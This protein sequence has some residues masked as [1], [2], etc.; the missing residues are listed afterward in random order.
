MK[1]IESILQMEL[2]RSRPPV[3]I[4]IGAS[5]EINPKWKQIA[6]YSI[7]IAFD[8]DDREFNISEQDNKAYKKLI[9]FNRIVTAEPIDKADFYLTNSP[10]CSS[11]LEPDAVNLKPWIFSSFFSTEKKIQLPAITL[12]Q[13]LSQIKIDYID[14]FK[15]DTQGTDLRL[16]KTLPTKISD[17]I[18]AAEFEPGIIDAYRGED[19]IYSV[20]EYLHQ[21]KFW[22]SSME[23]KGV[24]RIDPNYKGKFSSFSLRKIIRRSP[25]WAEVT[26]LR[27][28]V[29]NGKREILLLYIFALLEKQYGFALEITDFA[30]N[31]FQDTVFKDCRK[32][33]LK[34]LNAEKWKM[35]LVI[36][37]RQFNKL[38]TNI[39]D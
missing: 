20:M 10:F 21:H 28:P 18:L 9:T 29:L 32:A 38:F 14:W 34:K 11:L 27:Q 12:I 17:H 15:T 37:K 33:V 26:Y 16:F 35:P 22:L 8:A 4:D 23:P 1:I 31:N 25:C 2:F 36:F 6:P 30:L 19:K 5:G 24:Q 7:C 13:A 39:N 3:L